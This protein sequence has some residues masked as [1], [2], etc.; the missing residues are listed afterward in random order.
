MET[1]VLLIQILIPVM[2]GNVCIAYPNVGARNLRKENRTID[3]LRL[4]AFITRPID[5]NIARGRY[6]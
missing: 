6:D 2:Y 5:K 3:K 4:V 1:L